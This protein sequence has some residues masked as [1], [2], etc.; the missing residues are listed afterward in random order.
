[1]LLGLRA[2]PKEGHNVSAAEFLYGI[3]LALPGQLVGTTE[4][5]AAIFLEYLRRLLSFALPTRLLARPP[6][7]SDTTSQSHYH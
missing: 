2:A 6:A 7:P 3:P 5:P 4:P 1:M